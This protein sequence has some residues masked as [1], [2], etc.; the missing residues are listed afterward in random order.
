MACAGCRTCRTGGGESYAGRPVMAAANAVDRFG[1]VACGH[2]V[3]AAAAAEVLKD[4]GTAF[5]A[6]VAA[7]CAA[8]VC[9]PILASLAGGGF[10][11]ARPASG[12]PVVYDFFVQTPL[13]RQAPDALDFYDVEVDFG[14]VRQE[15]HIGVGAAA[16]PG[17]VRGLFDIH[18]DLCRLP[19]ARLMQPAIDAARTGV[20]V[21]P[22]QAYMLDTVAPICCAN[23]DV[24]GVYAGGGRRPLGEG[25]LLRQPELAD[26]FEA[27]RDEGAEVFYAG[28]MAASLVELCRAEGQIRPGDLASYRTIRRKPLVVRYRG[29]EIATNPLPS[30][31][32]LLVALTLGLLE[33][34]EPETETQ[35]IANLADAMRLTNQ[36]RLESGT[37]AEFDADL[38]RRY[39]DAM[40]GRAQARRG[41]THISVADCEGN[42]AAMTVSNGEGC[43]RFIPGTGIALNNMLGEEDINPGGFHSWVPGTRLASMMAPTLV[44]T[45]DQQLVV[46]TGG[47][48]RIRSAIVQAI[49]HLVRAGWSAEAAVT[50]PRLHVEGD[51]LNLEGGF[52]RDTEAVLESA[53]DD[54]EHW[55]RT[56]LFFGGVH[57]AGEREGRFV[58]VGDPRRGGT[59]R[60]V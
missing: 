34:T 23:E 55:G 1:A 43:G 32:G 51:L 40:H 26:S 17:Y 20:R 7:Q 33:D 9:E 46:G 41:T 44:E 54:V 16:T 31:G 52:S 36:A 28:E 11:L 48:N 12:D 15:F 35:R 50:A 14:G 25:D 37:M 2:P 60:V 18:A 58:A 10:L 21:T 47:S 22:L 19:L 39:Q 24:R 57:I 6:V 5:D 30:T 59:G 38:V 53:F 13:A 4:G 3:T 49:D 29:A 42:V 45:A 27:L 8:C 56:N